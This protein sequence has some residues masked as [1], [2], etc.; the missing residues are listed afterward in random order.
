MAGNC[1]R[2]KKIETPR[3]AMRGVD[4]VL[5][6]WEPRRILFH[7]EPYLAFD[8]GGRGTDDGLKLAG[9]YNP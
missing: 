7:L 8:V 6:G 2:I 3:I 5:R 9:L 4:A 1:F